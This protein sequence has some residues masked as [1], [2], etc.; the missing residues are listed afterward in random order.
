MHALLKSKVVIALLAVLGLAALIVLAGGLRDVSFHGGEA[1][2]V[3]ETQ[4]VSQPVARFI[5]SLDNMPLW[6]ALLIWAILLL[7]FVLMSLVL[8]PALRR[9][10]V[11]MFF[12]FTLIGFILF[13]LIRYFRDTFTNLVIPDALTT[14]VKI[15]G[16]SEVTVPV[17]EA[18]PA[19]PWLSF[20]VSLG[21]AIALVALVWGLMRWWER[22]SKFLALQ[23][24]LEDIA[25]I[26]RDS[27]DGL[28]AGRA[29]DDVILESYF[30]MAQVIEKR[31]GLFR[32][33]AMTPSEFAARLEQAGLPGDA[34]RKLTRLFESVRYGARASTETEIREATVC[35]TAILKYCGEA[36]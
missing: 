28:E 2:G 25:K 4:S 3:Q 8:S 16:G 30:R 10:L 36:V 32:E 29:W 18:P 24:P 6:K 20:V 19:S 11:R 31:R 34:V 13:L 15:E 27:L 1:L 9:Q 22:R 35:L 21:V 33:Q 17:F 7:I 5:N 12:R 26:A 23:R 14:Q